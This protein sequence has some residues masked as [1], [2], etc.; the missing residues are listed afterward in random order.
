[1]VQE[2]KAIM[3][4][5]ALARADVRWLGNRY[6]GKV[7]DT[8]QR[9]E[10]RILIATD[11]LSAF[12][13]VVTTVPGKGQILTQMASYWFNRTSHI[14][15]N[16]VVAVPDPCVMV[17]R[18]VSI[19]PIEVIVRGFLAGSAWRNYASGEQTSGVEFP[20]GMR[21]FERLRTPVVTP[22]TKEALGKHDQ[23][24]SEFEIVRR[25]IVSAGIWEEVRSK[26][27]ELF[28]FASREVSARGLLF[29]DTKYEFGLLDGKVI[30]ADEI[31][32]LDSSRF[33]L[34][35]SYERNVASGEA[36]EMLDKEPIRRWLVAQGFA[37]DGVVP[38]ISERY[39]EELTQ[40]YVRSCERITGVP[41]RLNVEDP[42]SRIERN[43]REYFGVPATA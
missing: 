39:R 35:D 32:T 6:E 41:C 14:V 38:A 17:G 37:G 16:H 42:N 5:A 19:I 26:A 3:P 13:R 31:H 23:P 10:L 9:E 25:G 8:Y 22:S 24:I 1:V 29:V 33:W 12:D 43:L 2:N 20:P 40:H 18:E 28:A 34:E 21:E 11:R 7:R 30:L 15:Q 27:L 36:P 4:P